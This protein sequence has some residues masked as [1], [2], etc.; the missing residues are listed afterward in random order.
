MCMCGKP[1][2][3]WCDF[4]FQ[5]RS[6]PRTLKLSESFQDSQG[7]SRHILDGHRQ[8]LVT[9]SQKYDFAPR[10]TS[11]NDQSSLSTNV[12]TVP[13][14]VVTCFLGYYSIL[15]GGNALFFIHVRY[16][17]T[18][19]KVIATCL[20]AWKNT[21]Q[22]NNVCWFLVAF[23]IAVQEIPLVTPVLIS[24]WTVSSISIIEE[25]IE[26]WIDVIWW[27]GRRCKQLLYDLN[28][29]TR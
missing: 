18:F 3:G 5:S 2:S 14:Q 24:S 13:G 22:E 21:T 26:E 25:K 19:M 12:R 7:L 6:L 27:R 28:K 16:V 8:F 23:H 11:F 15:T 1:L 20:C 29:T 10:L 4:K 17:S 9:L